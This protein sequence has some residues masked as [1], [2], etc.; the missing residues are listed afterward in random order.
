MSIPDLDADPEAEVEAETP[1][2][3]STM[4]RDRRIAVAATALALLPIVVA[5]ARA[6]AGDWVPV[7]DNALIVTRAYDVVRGP[8]PLLGSWTSASKWS[9][10]DMNFPG[11]TLFQ[12]L[13]VPVWL[14]GPF[15]GAAVGTGLVNGLAVVVCATFAWRM[16]R[17]PLLLLTNVGIVTLLASMGSS[18]LIDPWNAN[19]ATLTFM[20]LLFATAALLTGDVWG[21]PAAAVAVT[22]VLQTHLSYIMLGPGLAAAGLAGLGW[23][24]WRRRGDPS[25]AVPRRR[26]LTAAASTVLVVVAGWALPIYEQFASDPGNF[27]KLYSASEATPPPAPGLGQSIGAVSLVIARPPLWLP[28]SWGDTPL[29]LFNPPPTGFASSLLV[30]AVLLCLVGVAITAFRRG[31]RTAAAL[32]ATATVGLLLTI[33][34]A[35]R[36]TSPFGLQLAYVRYVWPMSMF[37]WLAIVH[38]AARS[39]WLRERVRSITVVF[40]RTRTPITTR[41]GSPAVLA[42]LVLLVAATALAVPARHYEVDAPT[43]AVPPARRFA[44]AAVDALGDRRGA[45]VELGL[46]PS[47][48]I[49]GPPVMAALVGKGY[50]VRTTDGVLTYQIGHQRLFDPER[51]ADLPTLVVANQKPSTRAGYRVRMLASTTGLERDDSSTLQRL[52]SRFLDGVHSDG[53]LRWSAGPDAGAEDRRSLED[54]SVRSPEWLLRDARLVRDQ[55]HRLVAPSGIT[56]TELDEMFEL[57]ELR[58]DRAI[59][60]YIVERA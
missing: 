57:A 12:A 23:S 45:L 47:S 6:V 39:P 59:S 15:R 22:F 1:S 33:L 20:A 4:R 32:A 58:L 3:G 36:A 25:V 11:P 26:L 46:V 30:S 29:D 41:F 44:T 5:V 18:N 2:E 56:P 52:T 19:I 27:T 10:I 50:D 54:L 16:G 51:D 40:D 31:D 35:S 53:G 28:P 37:S 13:A 7:G 38:G 14:F 48:A 34:T 43:W 60:L 55:R 42:G 49:V 21:L 17:L 24:V 8:Q 9:G